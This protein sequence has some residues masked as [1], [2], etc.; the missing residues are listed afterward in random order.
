MYDKLSSFWYYTMYNYDEIF[1]EALGIKKAFESADL[2]I[3]T[4]LTTIPNYSQAKFTSK[5]L[6]FKNLSNSFNSFE[7]KPLN[8]QIH[9]NP[10]NSSFYDS[11]LQK[12]FISNNADN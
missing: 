4:L 8:F 11:T 3:P 9:S 6:N 12:C 5:L 7:S 1:K 10:L 2:T